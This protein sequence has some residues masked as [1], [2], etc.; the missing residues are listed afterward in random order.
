MCCR[1]RGANVLIWHAPKIIGQEGHTHRP[2]ECGCYM[3]VESDHC[4][5]HTCKYG[6]SREEVLGVVIITPPALTGQVDQHWWGLQDRPVRVELQRG[7]NRHCGWPNRQSFHQQTSYCEDVIF[8]YC[9][10]LLIIVSN[11][12]IPSWMHLVCITFRIII[13]S[14][15]LTPFIMIR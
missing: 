5:T 6:L 2:L 13:I 12:S 15:T 11:V 1:S 3:R 4:L 10:V 14:C 7:S 8:L 9:V